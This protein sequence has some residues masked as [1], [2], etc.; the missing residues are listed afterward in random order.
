MFTVHTN[1][2]KRPIIPYNPALKKKARQ[3]RNNSTLSEVKLWAYLNGK[4]MHG[5]DFHRQRPV[6]QFIFVFFCCELYLAIELDG[7]THFLDKTSEKD[8][9]KEKRLCEL[10]I[11]LLRFRD[12]E[13]YHD[14][15]NVLKAIET[16]V[17]EQKEKAGL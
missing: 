3:L 16:V 14:I 1:S 8:L 7:Y 15:D 6:D 5:F 12:E 2:L 9:E 11:R 13:I 4:Q 10:G 17:L